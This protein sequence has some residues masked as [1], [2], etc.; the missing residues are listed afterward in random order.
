M[1]VCLSVCVSV[2]FL[3][4]RLNVFLPPLPEVGCPQFLEIWNPWGTVMKEVVS[5]LKFFVWK[6]SKIAKKKEADFA[7]Q[8]MV[9][10][11][12]LDGL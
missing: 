10:T 5:D 2:H 8:N 6:C 9:E 7:L 4:Y 1:S 11:M 12:L 3:S